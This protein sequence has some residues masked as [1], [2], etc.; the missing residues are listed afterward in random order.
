MLLH[1]QASLAYCTN[2]FLVNSNRELWDGEV[3]ILN[4]RQHHDLLP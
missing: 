2:A 3:V 4:F 1:C